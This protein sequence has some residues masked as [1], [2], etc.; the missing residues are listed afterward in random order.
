MCGQ[1]GRQAGGGI[2]PRPDDDDDD[3]LF[4]PSLSRFIISP[5][6]PDCCRTYVRTYEG[7]IAF[8]NLLINLPV[9]DASLSAAE[10]VLFFNSLLWLFSFP[11]SLSLSL[12]L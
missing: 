9:D 11:L 1:A 7:A 10:R 2:D 8:T 12:S 5:C 6:P 4:A 3:P